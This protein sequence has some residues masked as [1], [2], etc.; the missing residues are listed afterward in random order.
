MLIL[1]CVIAGYFIGKQFINPAP[2]DVPEDKEAPVG[3]ITRIFM[4]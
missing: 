4:Y 1:G 3:S 2:Q